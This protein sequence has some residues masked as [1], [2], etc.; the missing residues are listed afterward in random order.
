MKALMASC[1]HTNWD[2]LLLCPQIA[3]FGVFL[4]NNIEMIEFFQ[5]NA[6]LDI[7]DCIHILNTFMEIDEPEAFNTLYDWIDGSDEITDEM[8]A[9]R[10]S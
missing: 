7:N 6:D 9:Y 2:D 3:M 5:Q 1:F 8:I 4:S 10:D